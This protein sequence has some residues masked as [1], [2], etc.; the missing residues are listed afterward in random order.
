MTDTKM[1]FFEHLA[2]LRMRLLWV[3]GAILLCT[4]VNYYKI[5]VLIHFLKSP[6]INYQYEL[7][8]F[9]VTEGFVTRVKLSFFAAVVLISPLILHQ[10]LK[11]IH[12]GLNA[13]EKNILYRFIL[14]LSAA[15]IGGIIIGFFGV[16]PVTMNFLISYSKAYMMPALSGERYFSFIIL[17][18]FSTGIVFI[19]PLMITFLGRIK[20]LSSFLLRKS[21]KYVIAVIFLLVGMI[22]SGSDIFSILLLFLPLIGLFEMSIWMVFW[23]EKKRNV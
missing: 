8:Y 18:C 11:F 4:I 15:F 19:I 14:F 22:S 2:E 13:E 10:L 21:R 23:F 12:P 17:F 3:T 16:L 20:I 1:P 6:L 7:I 5:E 9:S